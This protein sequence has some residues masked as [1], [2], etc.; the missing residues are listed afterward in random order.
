[1]R[2]L[3]VVAWC[4]FALGLQAQEVSLPQL[5]A[6]LG[7]AD[8]TK[9]EA[10]TEALWKQGE[11]A[12]I[13]LEKARLEADAE[14]AERA[15]T[16]LDKFNMG[17]YANTPPEVLSRIRDFKS[18]D[19]T[20]Q[21]NAI[22]AMVKLGP[23]A[24][25][26]I[27]RLLMEP[28]IPEASGRMYELQS[29]LA[30]LVRQEAPRAIVAGK[31]ED[32]EAL[33][34]LNVVGRSTE[35]LLD[36]AE[37]LRSRHRL[38]PVLATLESTTPRTT[39][40][41]ALVIL[42]Q[43]AGRKKEAM[44]LAMTIE[45]RD[46][47]FREVVDSLLEDA[48]EWGKLATR[49]PGHVNSFEGLQAFRW[50]RAGNLTKA[51]TILDSQRESTN[52]STARSGAVDAPTM[53]LLLNDRSAEAIERLR[54]QRNA[55]QILADVLFSQMK[56]RE[57]LDL[58]SVR[59]KNLP[60]S[61][62]LDASLQPLYG[63][64]RGRVLSHL[65]NRD[66]ATQ[67]FNAVAQQILAQSRSEDQIVQ[68]IR[69]EVRSSRYDLACEHLAQFL[70]QTEQIN[71]SD[72]IGQDVFEILFDDD[73]EIAANLWR[74]CRPRTDE[75][76]GL[77]MLRLRDVLRG[78]ASAED[79][80]KVLAVVN[81]EK[82]QE[83]T[84]PVAVLHAH[85][86]ATV[87]R[88][89]G[90]TA[91]AIAA[92]ITLA[93]A[94]TAKPAELIVEDFAMRRSGRGHRAWVF[95]TDETYR[96]WVELADM[97]TELGRHRDAATRLMQA[98]QH[99]PSNPI[100]LHMAG[101]ALMKAG[102]VTYGEKRIEQS[103][104][105]ALGSSR[106]RGRFLEHLLNRGQFAD[107]KRV[108]ES[109]WQ[110]G[111]LAEMYVGNVW[112]QVAR[113]SVV[114]RDFPKAAIAQRKAIHYLLRTPGVSYIEGHA[115]ITVPQAIRGHEARGLLAVGKID[116]AMTLARDCMNVLPSSSDLALGMV[117]ELL[118]RDRKAEAD[119]LYQKCLASY[120]NLLK[121]HPESAW[122]KFSAAWLAA[123]CDRDLD[124]ALAY[125]KQ[126]VAAEPTNKAYRECLAEVHFRKSDRDAALAIMKTLAT[127]DRHNFHYQR[128][129]DRYRTADRTSPLPDT[130]D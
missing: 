62:A 87:L 123:G 116:E 82:P 34:A 85:T 26:A 88:A 68:L 29:H 118:R 2:F 124:A 64:R 46:N 108:A 57:A 50:S 11:A 7:D 80:D 59:P 99:Y 71:R 114:N 122:A 56:Y 83:K 65:G 72:R 39:H 6:Q 37:F 63:T 47:S 52:S 55:P 105:V 106:V 102:D 40:D 60:D 127:E 61:D 3:V 31:L 94:F 97:L 35:G 121:E 129:L 74:M 17:H 43:T 110:C 95:G 5:I 25:P 48:G 125:A 1:V 67:V 33:L 107:A 78:S 104:W 8:F 12:R 23:S 103:H 21:K 79:F 119:E 22:T 16:I 10:A 75:R 130:D 18:S 101:Q 41:R 113:A 54:N 73:A 9:R 30:Y 126:A 92:L 77:T 81:L 38:E 109:I 117:P 84:T 13:L 49:T 36:Y 120:S 20:G 42:L 45:S 89:K 66:A 112:N 90:D 32:A 98:H 115:Y 24:Y 14:I 69:A 51:T 93:D 44:Q 96:W 27:K 19:E 76:A 70:N 100:L 28:L 15:K 58:L 53:A 4:W 128:Q 111:W 86:L 91:G